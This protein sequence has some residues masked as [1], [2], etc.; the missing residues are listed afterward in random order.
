MIVVTGATGHIGNV[1]V[2]KLLADG[3]VVRGLIP[4][5]ED[6]LPLRGLDLEIVRGDVRD[7]E[8]LMQ[9]FQ[10]AKQVYHLAGAIS[11]LPGQR[12]LLEQINVRGTRNVV[13]ACL[14]TGVTRLL[15]ASSIHAVK[16]PP[17][18]IAITESQPYDP[19]SVLGDYA[20]SK[21]LATLE[22]TRG[23]QRGLEAVIVCPTGIIG[24]YDYKL[25]EMGRLIHGFLQRKQKFCIVGGYDFLDVR[26]AAEGMIQACNRGQPGESYLL[27]GEWISIRGLFSLL[28]KISGIRAPRFTVS[29]HLARLAGVLATPYYL[30]R[31]TKP[32]FT[33]YSID[34]LQSNAQVSS[35]KARRDLGFSPRPI[36]ESLRDTVSW[37]QEQLKRQNG[38]A[39]LPLA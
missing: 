34:V 17:H 19:R 6:T 5:N 30:L 27:S 23:I 25:S 29:N 4:P 21:A 36:A 28:E 26:D 18:G 31:K 20:K 39:N 2:R 15:Y 16:E 14:Q 7:A 37:F 12:Q 13:D 11:I 33:A 38:L 24:P 10:G 8:S 3:K 22:V 9:A 35:E 32:L 1:L